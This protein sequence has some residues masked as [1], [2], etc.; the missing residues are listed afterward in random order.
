VY[1]TRAT[2]EIGEY[3]NRASE[4]ILEAFALRSAVSAPIIAEGRLWGSV[5][6]AF[7]ADAFIPVDAEQRLTS[8]ALLV[9]LAIS[10]AE[11]LE[12]LSRQ[13][14]TDPITGLANYRS[15]HE[16]LGSEVERSVRHGRALSVAV[17]D[18]D[19]FKQVNDTHGHQTGDRVLVE[20]A[21]RLAAAV[22]SG[23]LMARIGGEEFAWLMPEASADGAFAAAERVRRAIV[24]TPFDTAGSLTISVGVCSN[25]Q[26]QTGEELV[27]RADQALYWS[28]RSGR[29]TTLIY[30]HAARHMFPLPTSAHAR[31]A[32]YAR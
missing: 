3:K 19:H 2:A 5:G 26:A 20:V 30:T 14:T 4:P 27:D 17:L 12:T 22:R 24:D 9:S 8:F 25:Q 16:R 23:E 18:L 28:K 31:S 10:S 15:F 6:L 1:Q 29:N 13:A 32:Q 21:R 11:A 7:A